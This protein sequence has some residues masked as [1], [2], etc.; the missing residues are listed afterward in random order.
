MKKI[1]T[2]A[3]CGAALL[4]GTA[5]PASAVPEPPYP[6]QSANPSLGVQANGRPLS[7]LSASDE[8]L[9]VVMSGSSYIPLKTDN[10]LAFTVR[11]KDPGKVTSLSAAVRGPDET[12]WR[13]A[14]LGAPAPEVAGEITLGPD[15]APGDWTL[16][17]TVNGTKESTY[18]FAVDPKV[19]L[20]EI[21]VSPDP[22]ALKRDGRTEV[23]VTAEATHTDRVRGEL[24]SADGRGK[25]T[26]DGLTRQADGTWRG[27]AALTAKT[28]GGRWQARITAYRGPD[29]V[30]D[31]AAFTVK[32]GTPA[33]KVSL[34]LDA[35]PEPVRAGKRLTLTGKL[36]KG[37]KPY[38]KT[39]VALY[40]KK[41]GAKRYT[42]VTQVKTDAKGRYT[43][44]AV[45][46]A[47]GT[48][49]AKA[50]GKSAVDTVDVR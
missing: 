37:A 23:T 29:G 33:V 30:T 43:A 34:T 8:V 40:F 3:L 21:S 46:R 36:L 7:S 45:A 35:K 20:G 12:T 9:N 5:S 50:A 31:D 49:M 27:T 15:D 17:V 42:L 28:A 48:W 1:L 4:L 24:R 32:G 47:D 13:A 39:K 16:R 11:L 18:A 44:S 19:A 38:A 6:G 2:G 14:S 22:V 10:D 25:V 26:L 41:R